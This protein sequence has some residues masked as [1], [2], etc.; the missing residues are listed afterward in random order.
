MHTLLEHLPWRAAAEC[1][2]LLF[3]IK[4]LPR[5]R[6]T[7]FYA[8]SLFPKRHFHTQQS[9]VWNQQKLGPAG[10]G[11]PCSWG[12]KHRTKHFH[13]KLSAIQCFL[14][15]LSNLDKP[16]IPLQGLPGLY[17]L[18]FRE[19]WSVHLFLQA[20]LTTIMKQIYSYI[21]KYRAKTVGWP[22]NVDH[23]EDCMRKTKKEREQTGKK[24]KTTTCTKQETITIN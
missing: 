6:P 3:S 19:Q 15:V 10:T 12:C 20:L 23:F 7:T 9:W 2:S 5:C 4:C 24:Q 8:S 11:R 18:T 13:L 16:M 1:I 14:E 22:A 21:L 17:L